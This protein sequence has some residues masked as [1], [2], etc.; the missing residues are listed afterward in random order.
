MHTHNLSFHGAIR[1]ICIWI[2][3]LSG[4]MCTCLFTDCGLYVVG[5]SMSG[6][7]TKSSDMDLC[8][9]LSPHQVCTSKF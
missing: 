3:I 8:L 6:F 2:C 5:S 4:A 7:G 9:M 1:K